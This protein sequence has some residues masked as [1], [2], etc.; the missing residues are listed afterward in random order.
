MTHDYVDKYGIIPSMN[1]KKF[2]ELILNKPTRHHAA[3]TFIVDGFKSRR[4]V[5]DNLGMARSARF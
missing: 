2:A 4:K 3:T 1:V 5:R